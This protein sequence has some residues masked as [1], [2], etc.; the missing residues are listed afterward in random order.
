MSVQTSNIA[1]NIPNNL[2][3]F[4]PIVDALHLLSPFDCL[5]NMPKVIPDWNM[6]NPNNMVSL[7]IGC[8]LL[9]GNR[10]SAANFVRPANQHN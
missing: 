10:A 3:I 1:H 9:Y 8:H 2:W 6:I 4:I 7:F 5:V